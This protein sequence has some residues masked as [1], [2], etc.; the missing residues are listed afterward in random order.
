MSGFGGLF[1]S[2][3]GAAI[4]G[5]T[6]SAQKKEA[7]KLMAK[8]G[9]MPQETIAPE[10]LENKTIASIAATEGL[11]SEQYAMAQKNIKRN[12]MAAIRGAQD[13]RMA[14]G[15]I[16]GIQDNTNN[17]TLKL[18]ATN[19]NARMNNQKGLIQANQNISRM[20]KMIYD[21]YINKNYLPTLNYARALRGA[22]QQNAN[23]AL[24]QAISGIAGSM[25]S[26]G[27][28][29]GGGFSFGGGSFGGGGAS[30]SW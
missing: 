21:N 14:G 12:E 15:M 6:A 9:E 24:D 22:G 16:T 4:K 29:G 5:T 30:G 26:M 27:G 3:A 13:R 17:A 18:D 11:P 23:A 8:I 25:G 28:G 20:R 10:L 7:R 2:L 19:A 1:S